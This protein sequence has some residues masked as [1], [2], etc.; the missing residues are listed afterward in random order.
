M[1][2]IIAGTSDEMHALGAELNL[3]Y[4]DEKTEKIVKNSR[5]SDLGVA[6]WSAQLVLSLFVER[7][8]LSAGLSDLMR[9]VA[10]NTHVDRK[11]L[12]ARR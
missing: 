11:D 10:R 5:E 4:H 2:D 1:L 3:K 8:A 7:D 9:V 12:D 6:R